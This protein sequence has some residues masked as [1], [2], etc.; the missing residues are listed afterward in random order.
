MGRKCTI[1]TH[2]DADT[3]DAALVSGTSY[4][5]IAE[6]HGLAATSVHRHAQQHLSAVLA[7]SDR[8]TNGS[9]P[10]QLL[11]RITALEGE[12][13]RLMT[14]A[15]EAGELRTALSAVRELVRIV[16]LLAKI[17]GELTEMPVVNLTVLPQWQLIE[18][19]ILEVLQSHPE[20]RR[21]LAGRLRTVEAVSST[22]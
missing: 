5:A 7:R 3:I 13:R 15:E 8:F 19:T 1:C 9:D 12:A 17:R 14:K 16:E 22:G 6:Q 11:D 2:S 10:E 20:L 18:T 4:R 21:E